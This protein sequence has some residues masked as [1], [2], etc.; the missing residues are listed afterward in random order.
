M[1]V[2]EGIAVAIVED[3]A[4]AR[5]GL[6]TLLGQQPD[7]R[8]VGAVADSAGL[9]HIMNTDPA[10]VILMDI[11]LENEN[12]IALTRQ[13]VRAHPNVH[14]IVL[15]N[16]DEGPFVVEAITAGAAGYLLKDCST[17]LLL[18]T[19]HAVTDGAVLFKKELLVRAF[20]MVPP[21]ASE[22]EPAAVR[23]LTEE[24]LKVLTL[25]ASGTRNRVIGTQLNLSEATVKKRVQSILVKLS[26]TNRTEAV[27]V[28]TR[29]GVISP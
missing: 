13:V 24:E 8:V 4:L 17:A 5:E 28:A 9:L 22:E 7:L 2:V 15:S 18:H 1:E 19:I 29:A 20:E 12:G 26:V 10:D 23:S 3:H 27:A 11:V 6:S 16:F 14:V 25:I 21:A